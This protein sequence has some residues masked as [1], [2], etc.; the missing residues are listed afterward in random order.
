M[1]MMYANFGQQILLAEMDGQV[2]TFMYVSPERTFLARQTAETN[3]FL[4]K[5]KDYGSYF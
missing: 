1:Y 2:V 5:I 3:F 4:L